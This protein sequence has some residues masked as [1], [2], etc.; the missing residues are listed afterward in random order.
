MKVLIV[1]SLFFVFG[2]KSNLAKAQDLEPRCDVIQKAVFKKSKLK[3]C[4]KILDVELADN[5]WFREIG[6]MCRDSMPE[7]HGMI[8]IFPEEKQLTFWM[9]NTRIPLTVGYFDKNKTLVDTYDMEPMNE[10]KLYTASKDS[11]YALETNQG[12]FKKNKVNPGCKFELIETKK[13]PVTKGQ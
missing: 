2:V 8:F 3:I 9:K 5:E 11:L 1:V 6:L 4:G 13:K 12:W 10:S 7:N